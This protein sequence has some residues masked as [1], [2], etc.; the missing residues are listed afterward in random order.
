MAHTIAIMSFTVQQSTGSKAAQYDELIAQARSLLS[1]E[2]D[3][4]AN[5]ANF[6]ALVYHTLPDLN[7]SGFYF[8][9]GVEL[10]VGPFQGNRRAFASRWE[11]AYAA[12]RP[13]PGSHRLCKTFTRFPDTLRATRL[14]NRRLSCLWLPRTAL[15]P[16]SGMSTALRSA[17][18]TRTMPK[19]WKRYARYS[20]NW[21]GSRGHRP[22]ALIER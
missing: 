3:C 11:K 14:R 7:W 20:W 10:V 5:A 8:F 16:A 19:E 1:D 17:A 9:D 13:R 4:I 12:L 22:E 18:S 2:T 6:S 21:R 15:W